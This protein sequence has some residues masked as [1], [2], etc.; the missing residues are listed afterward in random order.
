MRKLIS[1]ILVLTLVCAA[2]G[3][4]AF[5]YVPGTYTGEGQGYQPIKV[6]ITVDEGVITDVVIEHTETEGIGAA[7]SS[8]R[9]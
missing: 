9:A 7:S 6:T 4:T 2:F 1:L 3:T 5:A 8:R